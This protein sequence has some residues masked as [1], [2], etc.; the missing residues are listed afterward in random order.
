MPNNTLCIIKRDMI[1]KYS[2]ILKALDLELLLSFIIPYYKIFI[3]RNTMQPI[4][5]RIFSVKKEEIRLLLL[6]TGFIFL[7]FASYAIL[8]PLRDTLGLEGGDTELKWL[9]LATFVVMCIASLA[10]MWLSTKL[11]RKNYLNA[12]YLFFVSNLIALYVAMQSI[13]PHTE[14]FIWLCRVF[15]V[16]VSVFNLFVI[17]SAWSLLTDVFERDSSRRLFG[18]ISAG[19]SFGSIAGSSLVSIF[20]ISTTSFIFASIVFLCL[21]LWIKWLLI[22]EA[23]T[24]AKNSNAFLARFQK[25]IGSSNPFAGFWLILRSKYLLAL[26]AFILLLTSVNTFL[27]MEQMRIVKELF[28]T[29]E[30]RAQA[31]ANINLIIQTLSFVFQIFLTAKIV[32]Y[33][34][35]KW[36]L[37]LLGFVMGVGFIVLSYTHPLF[38]PLVIAMCFRSVGE[39]A[40]VKPGREM[41]F[42]P[43][44]SDAKY[45]VKNFLDTAVYRGGDALSA[46]IESA[47]LKFGVGAALLVGAALSFLWGFV[48]LYLA[49]SYEKT[50]KA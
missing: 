48:G 22:R 19:A 42:V 1:A 10:S 49:K 8:R 15:Y 5:Q 29:R 25:T 37:S 6:S 45:K 31:F 33:F 32:E 12:I 35:I 21:A 28:P 34:G 24:I 18:I 43:L 3:L 14:A 26:L 27:Y 7:L 9:F 4:L 2:L 41:L 40:L 20:T 47:V 16:W 50:K 46:Q 11:K 13:A 39:Y 17:S 38:L 36:L 30:E 23:S 44:D